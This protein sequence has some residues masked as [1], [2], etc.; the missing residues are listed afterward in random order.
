MSCAT[1]SS[2]TSTPGTPTFEAKVT[3]GQLRTTWAEIRRALPDPDLRVVVE[4]GQ[5]K[6]VRNVANATGLGTMHESHL[7][8]SRHWRDQLDRH[9]TAGGTGPD[10]TAT[11]RDARRWIDEVAGGPRG[12][13]NEVA[14]LIIRTV[15]AL[16]DHRL[17]HA[18]RASDDDAGKPLPSDV[19]IVPEELPDTDT[20]EQAVDLAA[21]LFG[22]TVS[23]RVTGPELTDLGNLVRDKATALRADAAR[24]ADHLTA[25]YKTWGLSDGARL[26]TA[27][28]SRDL[29]DDLAEAD[30]KKVVELLSHYQPPGSATACRDSLASAGKVSAALGRANL[31]LWDAARPAVGDDV[32]RLLTNEETVL[33]FEAT[34]LD[35]ERRATEHLRSTKPP[36]S[37]TPPP[38]SPPPSSDANRRRT[39]SN[40][41]DL[42]SLASALT[43]AIDEHGSITVTWTPS[44]G[45]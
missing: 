15:A 21:T 29:V 39:I 1:R 11:V 5:R 3:A 42:Q 30:D 38:L 16:A 14:D 17:V 12:L 18:G 23:K 7:V 31:E 22:V 20:W 35:I 33:G 40:E 41:A 37:P 28:S 4:S 43:K 45:T 6:A 19:R 9:L 25:A 44:D 27:R 13:E 34:E 24:L 32:D 36:E 10:G 2:T 26:A 8:V